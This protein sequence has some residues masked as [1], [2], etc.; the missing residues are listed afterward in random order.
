[1]QVKLGLME[2]RLCATKPANR[3]SE[4]PAPVM[5]GETDAHRHTGEPEFERG[6][7]RM[8]EEDAR[9]LGSGVF[10]Y[11]SCSE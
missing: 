9:V 11:L 1:M 4:Q 10:N 5:A 6:P 8:W 3:A 7:E 2:Q